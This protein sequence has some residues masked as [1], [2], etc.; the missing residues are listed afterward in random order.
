MRSPCPPEELLG[1]FLAEELSPTTENDLEC[2]RAIAT[3]VAIAWSA[4]PP[5][6]NRRP[7]RNLILHFHPISRSD[8]KSLRSALDD[9]DCGWDLA[10][11]EIPGYDLLESIGR[12]GSSIVFALVTKS[13]SGS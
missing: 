12:G 10:L 5:T 8:W 3:A 13:C 11:P 2:T 1:Q 4:S 6:R 7:P 9:S